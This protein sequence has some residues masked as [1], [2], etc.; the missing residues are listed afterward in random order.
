MK[1]TAIFGSGVLMVFGLWGCATQNP[2]NE[3]QPGGGSTQLQPVEENV[4]AG[5]NTDADAYWKQGMMY[6]NGNRV[7]RDGAE[8]ARWF[9]KAAELG[10]PR[11]QNS[12]GVMYSKGDG[13]AK[14]DAEAVRW[15]RKAAVQGDAQGQVNLGLKYAKGTGVARNDG[16]A[17]EWF[18]RAAQQGAADAQYN[19]GFMYSMG[20]G[21][22]QNPS[23][24]LKWMRL[25][26][27]QGHAKAKIVVKAIEKAMEGQ[28]PNDLVP[29]RLPQIRSDAEQGD[30]NA[31]LAVGEFYYMGLGVAKDY[32]KA[33]KWFRK[34]AS[35]GNAQAQWALGRMY[36][37]G[38]GVTRNATEA[39][40][41]YRKAAE[42]GF[43]PLSAPSE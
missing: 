4:N 34:A 5:E 43:A 22:P 29:S 12:L 27:A 19:L 21:V 42:Q 25:A 3:V 14:D 9:H 1:L 38:N 30:A 23:E 24:A 39:A 28:V 11:G 37:S 7:A 40:N 10:D 26:A 35:Q 18:R 36:E 2:P 31:Q 13:V 41:W 8:A 32:A 20:S 17:L 16:E 33:A 6:L 15:Y